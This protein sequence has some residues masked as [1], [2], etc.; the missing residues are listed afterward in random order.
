MAL[1]RRREALFRRLH[2]RRTRERD[3]LFLVE[4]VRGAEEA[5]AGDAEIRAGLFSP[6]LEGTGAG[7]SVLARLRAAGVA[8]DAVGREE[9]ARAVCTETPQGVALACVEPRWS[10]DALASDTSRARPR[11]L[12]LDAVQDPGNC[13]T[14]VR[15]AAA[16]GLDGVVALD[17]TVDPWNPK[18]VRAAAGGVF[19]TRLVREAWAGLAAW[20][21]R[22]G[23]PLLAG[24]ADGDDVERARPGPGWVLAVGNEGGGL[25]KEVRRRADHVVAIPMP[26]TAE[27]LNVAVAGSILLYA[28]TRP[29]GGPGPASDAV[30]PDIDDRTLPNPGTPASPGGGES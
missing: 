4:G 22:R 16:F 26:G 23:L 24:E 11:I 9:M 6:D 18:S 13:G 29:H 15:A 2:D 10:L 5:L 1:S 21:D 3:G 17:G 25:R 7:R 14:L 19:R 28:L 30:P 12:V 8:L 20:L 27:S